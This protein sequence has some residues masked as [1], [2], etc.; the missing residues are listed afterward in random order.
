MRWQLR[1][2]EVLRV[3]TQLDLMSLGEMAVDYDL[4]LD[5]QSLRLECCASGA[6]V[7]LVIK[8][9]T[10]YSTD[11]CNLPNCDKE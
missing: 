9:I 11:K 10:I 1:K 8:A 6:C 7:Q 5:M 4:T 2:F 3:P